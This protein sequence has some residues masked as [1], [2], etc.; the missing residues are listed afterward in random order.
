MSASIDLKANPNDPYVTRKSEGTAASSKQMVVQSEKKNVLNGYRSFTYNFTLSALDKNSVNDP[1]TYRNNALNYVILK[2]GGKGSEG[3]SS[4]GSLSSTQFA[5]R[6]RS[7]FA[8]RDPR[9]VDISEDQGSQPLRNYGTELVTGFNQNSPGRFDLFID[10]VEIETIMSFTKEGGSTLP[11]SIKFRVTEPYSINGFIEALHVASVACGYLNYAQAS[12]LLK[13]EFIGYPD[14]D[15]VTFK[16]PKIIERTTRY[17][18]IKLA[19]VEVEVGEKGTVYRCTAIPWNDQAFGQANVLRRP[20]TMAGTNVSEILKNLATNLNKQILDDDK[21]AKADQNVTISDEYEIS[22]PTKT[23]SGLDYTK[24]NDIGTS[25]LES[26][27]RN[28]SIFKFKDPGEPQKTQTPQEKDAAPEEVKLHPTSGTPPQIQFAENQQ[29]NEIIAAVVRDSAYV[30]KILNEKKIDP[31]GFIDYFVIKS[32]VIN[33]DQIDP[34]TRKPY[35]K[36]RFSVVP[37]KVHFTRIPTLASQ[38]YD[39]GP[40]NK[41]SLREYNYIYTGNNVDVLNFKLNFNTLF[42]EAIPTAMGNNDQ[43]G[44]RDTAGQPNDTQ[45]KVTGDDTTNLTTDQ[46]PTP[47]SKQVALPVVMNGTNASQ[48]SDDPYYSLARNMHNAIIDSKSSMLSGEIEILG[49]PLYLVTGGI[50][51][52]DP[53]PSGVPGLTEDGEADHFNGEILIT[54]NFRNPIDINS[55]EK[56]GMFYFETEKLP[57]SGVYRI[58]KVNSIFNDGLFKQRVEIVRIPGQI[59]GRTRETSVQEKIKDDPKPGSQ[60]LPTTTQGTDQAGQPASEA[61]LATLLSRGLPSPGLPG[62]LSNFVGAVGGLGGNALSALNQVSGAVSRGVGSLV[63]S[64]SV[65]GGSIPGSVDQ[66][67]SGIRLKTS[68]LINAAQANLGDAAALVQSTNILQSKLPIASGIESLT[69]DIV[70]NATNL[71]NKVS[72]PGSGIGEG[73][74]VFVNKIS[75]IPGAANIELSLN[76]LVPSSNF[77]VSSAQVKN[78]GANALSV[79][80]SLGS[81]S[82]KLISSV[83]SKITSVTSG[84]PSDPAAIAAKFGINPAQLSGLGGD[85]KSKVTDQL[86]SIA[87]NISEDIDISVATARGLALNY[88]PTNKLGNIPATAPYRTAPKPEVDKLFLASVA[89]SGGPQALANAFGVSNIS[90]ISSELL[91][92]ESANLLLSQVSN[93]LKNPLSNLQN[94]LNLAD[95]SSLGGK[96]EGARNLVNSVAPTLSSVEAGISS[97]ARQIGD[98]TTNVQALKTSVTAKFGSSSL[99]QSPLSKLLNG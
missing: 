3:I 80:T 31:N 21:K 71:L 8:A 88:I 7:D 78:L 86:S 64:N 63:G 6:A 16:N 91:P 12:F 66:L 57:F 39:P 24:I 51:N 82:S 72:I 89:K 90:N 46:N 58:L 10:D 62:A 36:F 44:S 37:Y 92:T 22:F 98:A 94:N 40:I 30:K 29:I 4:N 28:N 55:L 52:Y 2:S 1:S 17:F 38:K 33:K 67:A 97:V 83:G 74:S 14:D 93:A 41:L 45:A 26:I 20:V 15:G 11:C 18:P 75:N 49:D 25:A 69:S 60:Q 85:L 13:M 76:S 43:P 53:K 61:N 65:F 54:I 35:Q 87:K 34:T 19:G 95:I 47:T 50:G 68:G 79:V 48:R 23:D 96:I 9:R 70:S 56:G 73:A 84:I 81:E 32:D 42:F 27:L 59:I 99:G 5:S 77:S